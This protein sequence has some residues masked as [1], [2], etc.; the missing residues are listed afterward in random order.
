MGAGLVVVLVVTGLFVLL[1]LWFAWLSMDSRRWQRVERIR[2]ISERIDALLAEARQLEIPTPEL[3][4]LIAERERL[5]FRSE[6][7]TAR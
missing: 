6:E 5:M 4:E 2:I 3:L 7:V 1:P